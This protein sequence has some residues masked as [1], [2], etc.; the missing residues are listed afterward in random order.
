MKNDPLVYD[1]TPT[2]P[3]FIIYTTIIFYDY[4]MTE[5][6][7]KDTSFHLQLLQGTQF[8]EHRWLI[9]KKNQNIH[10]C[11]FRKK[12]SRKNP[13]IF[14]YGNSTDHRGPGGLLIQP[15]V[16]WMGVKLLPPP[17]NISI[18]NMCC[19]PSTF[20]LNSSIDSHL[21]QRHF[22]SIH[23]KKVLL[24]FKQSRLLWEHQD[25]TVLINTSFKRSNF[26]LSIH[27]TSALSYLLLLNCHP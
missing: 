10:Q 18:S 6:K 21:N 26:Q 7:P 1:K 24:P 9:T 20:T 16:K 14:Q 15:A 27:N 13:N 22:F 12:I 4:V 2:T 3:F 11:E 17:F 8:L 19:L 5:R 25:V 23:L